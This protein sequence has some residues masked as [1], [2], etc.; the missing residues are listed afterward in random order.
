MKSTF[1]DI[2]GVYLYW[3]M[4]CPLPPPRDVDAEVSLLASSCASD[5]IS[6]VYAIMD[7]LR[8]QFLVGYC[9]MAGPVPRCLIPRAE[10]RLASFTEFFGIGAG[11]E[12]CRLAEFIYLIN[13]WDKLNFV[14]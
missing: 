7:D 10:A 2:L 4:N 14:H 11:P 9:S 12:I 6:G 8:E 1:G 5:D 13:T 3:L